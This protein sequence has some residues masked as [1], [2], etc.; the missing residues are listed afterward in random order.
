MSNN[1]RRDGRVE[2]GQKIS[3]AFSAR[4]WNRAQDAA[5]I[6]LGDRVR[7][8]AQSSLQSHVRTLAVAIAKTQVASAFSSAPQGVSLSIGTAV[9]LRTVSPSLLTAVAEEDR[10]GMRVLDERDMPTISTQAQAVRLPSLQFGFSE[11]F[12][13]VAGINDTKPESA[14]QGDYVLT[15]IVAGVFRCIVYSFGTGARI[16]G[17]FPIPPQNSDFPPAL[18]R[19]YPVV[20]AAGVGDLIATGAYYK[21]DTT[22]QWPRL[23]EAVIRL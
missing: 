1:T 22:A 10:D 17:A 11:S 13:V 16:S 6:V 19:P 23:Y 5:D 7:F 12:G 15:V 18:W 20:A 3:S 4:A 9:D 14:T 21:L 2:S 8:G